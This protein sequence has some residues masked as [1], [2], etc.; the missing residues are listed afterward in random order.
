[1]PCAAGG[2]CLLG[3]T[4]SS[5]NAPDTSE[6]SV[7]PTPI[8]PEPAVR[9]STTNA[10][11]AASIIIIPNTDVLHEHLNI[12]QTTAGSINDRS[13]RSVP[14][15][16]TPTAATTSNGTAEEALNNGSILPGAYDTADPLHRS[17]HLPAAPTSTYAIAILSLSIVV[18]SSSTLVLIAT[19]FTSG[20]RSAT[21]V[22]LRSLCLSDILMST[23]GVSKMAMLLCMED[24]H[25][26]FFLP[27]SLF[28]T[29]SLASTMS[30]L[31]L[32]VDC[33]VKLTRPLEY[34]QQV[35]KDT[36]ITGMLLLWNVAFIVGFLPLLGWN[37][38]DFTVY[39][40]S[41]FPWHYLL[42]NG[43]VMTICVLICIA[44]MVAL[45]RLPSL[46]A[47]EPDC[48][49][50]RGLE[51]RKYRR[52]HRTIV[53]E[54]GMWLCC[55]LPFFL[56][57][58]LA[59]PQCPLSHYPY[60]DSAV[61]YFIP[62][63]LVKSLLSSALQAVRTLHVHAIMN[64]LLADFSVMRHLRR[65]QTRGSG[66][67]GSGERGRERPAQPKSAGETTI[68]YINPLCSDDEGGGENHH[69]QNRSITII[70]HRHN[71]YH[72][73]H[74]HHRYPNN[75]NNNNNRQSFLNQQRRRPQ[76]R[77]DHDL[78]QT[79]THNHQQLQP[80][81]LQLQ[82]HYEQQEVHHQQQQQQQR[83]KSQSRFTVRESDFLLHQAISDSDLTDLTHNSDTPPSDTGS[84]SSPVM[85]IVNL[86]FRE[87]IDLGHQTL[88]DVP[89]ETTA[90]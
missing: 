28:F 10:S 85:G 46:P 42:F 52:L 77:E 15:N 37:L 6:R 16:T 70:P 39:F 35:D 40:F 36:V 9:T 69:Q 54:S 7:V 8:S 88:D 66:S 61:L 63:F 20:G 89:I 17:H 2:V 45:A 78:T 24:L 14:T 32:N 76:S 18:F 65:M 83:Q 44:C 12:S 5:E 80:L 1:M 47:P 33:F 68:S 81:Q 50:A 62:V 86:A 34:A 43:L 75:N 72:Q 19:R 27:E 13:D 31:S 58:G 21:L 79:P 23:Y 51:V 67:E 38:Q 73:R 57:L 11:T 25:V 4:S 60:R 53:M 90:L 74:H 71:D 59:C 22:F 30:L 55:Y 82:Q 48:F 41:F 56:Y 49:T 29:A 64:R 3:L 87:S 26:N 84:R